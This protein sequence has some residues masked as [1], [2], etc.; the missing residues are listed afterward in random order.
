MH[1]EIQH[2][3]KPGN[4]SYQLV[5]KLFSPHLLSQNIKIEIYPTVIL[6]DAKG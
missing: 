5:Q 6:D 4:A 2:T 1:E 3:L